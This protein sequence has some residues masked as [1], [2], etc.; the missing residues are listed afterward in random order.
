MTVDGFSFSFSNGNNGN[1]DDKNVI[2]SNIEANSSSEN[3]KKKIDW[4]SHK[5]NP[6]VNSR[7]L[8]NIINQFFENRQHFT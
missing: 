3:I 6:Q 7:I 1:N 5:Y 8:Q 4:Q 2:I